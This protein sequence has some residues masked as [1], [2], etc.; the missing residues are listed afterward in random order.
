MAAAG[1]RGVLVQAPETG[2]LELA[3]K[4]DAMGVQTSTAKATGLAAEEAE[5]TRLRLGLEGSRPFRFEGGASLT[6]S[7]EIGVHQDGGDA[8]TGFGVDI[9]GGLDWSDPQRGLSVEIRGRGLLSHDADGFRERGFSGSLS[10]DP[11]PE[12]ARGLRLSMSQTVGTQASGGVDALLEGGP[13]AGLAANDDGE[14]ALAQRRFEIKTRLRDVRLRWG[15]HVDT[16][17]RSGALAGRPRLQPG[18]AT[19]ARGSVRRLARSVP[20]GAAA[21]VRERR[22]GSRPRDR[23]QGDGALL[24]ADRGCGG[25]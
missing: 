3:A 7:I 25:R 13:L 22:R 11:T 24:R 10:W 21:G 14:S 6:P 5:V 15:L 1:L 8:E 18:L 19:H 2:G 9:R 16:G 23:V 20:R 4:T 12:T 17:D